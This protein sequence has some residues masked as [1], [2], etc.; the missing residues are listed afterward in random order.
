MKK[1][2]LIPAIVLCVACS[3]HKVV[4]VASAEKLRQHVEYLSDDACE[5]RGPFTEGADR[6]AAYIASQMQEIGLTPVN[7]D[8]YLQSV[9]L[10]RTAIRTSRTMSVTTE[11]GPL[12]LHHLQDYTAFNQV[13]AEE[14]DIKDAQLVFAGYGIVAPE[15]GKDDYR[16]LKNPENKI[17]IVIINDPGLGTEGDY[18]NG[19]AMTY[20]GRW[21]YKYEEGIRQGLRGV[22]I[23]HDERGAGY[24]WSTVCN[25]E[26]LKFALNEPADSSN[27]ALRGWLSGV[28]A[29][30]LFAKCGYD[31]NILAKLAKKPD[32]KPVELNASISLS[33]KNTLSYAESPNVVGYIQGS[34]PD[35]ECV[36][37]S[38]HWDGLGRASTPVDGD[39][40]IN[41]A[42]DNATGVAW[43]L[44]VARYFA[45]RGRQPKRSI[46]FLSPTC[47]EMGMWGTEYYVRHPLFPLEKTVA[48]VNMDFIPL[49]GEN[50][51]VTIT[52]Y[53]A[54]NLDSLM[55][56]RAK[57]YGRYVM[58]DPDAHNGMFYRS[59]QL[60]FMRKGVPAMYAK[61][62]SDS[63]LHGA[64]W[65][66]AMKKAYWSKVYHKPC[67][68]PSPEDDY[69]GLVQDVNLFCDF[70]SK[71][72]DTNFWP[73]WSEKA[74]FRR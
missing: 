19:D 18:F 62:W 9:P 11:A 4:N 49:W 66:S 52:G 54:S 12:T 44:E 74:E 39:D 21:K 45:S 6:A 40:I 32:F 63:R 73:S 33:M 31:F 5:G 60:P 65:S 56:V 30:E 24:P 38:A 70:I 48:I 58:A 17:A 16:G 72:A 22:L 7:A 36:V 61:G 43:M 51:D 64:D 23:V 10:V 42:T 34:N 27:F 59:V 57:R 55:E 15:Y 47:E 41:G 25:S 69:S 67:D 1:I 50:N 13:L 53:G 35:G 71:I 14:I 29:K 28:G 46:V 68:Q 8:G 2:L 37:C 20:Y 26:G 3:G